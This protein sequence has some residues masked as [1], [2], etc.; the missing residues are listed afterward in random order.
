MKYLLMAL[1]TMG[2]FGAGLPASA[3]SNMGYRLLNYDQLMK[4]KKKDR[5]AY[6]V[7]LEKTLIELEEMQGPRENRS[8]SGK[9]A[10]SQLIPMHQFLRKMQPFWI[11][12]A[13]AGIRLANPKKCPNEL[14]TYNWDTEVCI[15]S[16]AFYVVKPVEASTH[17]ENLCPGGHK[18]IIFKSSS[19]P[20][21]SSYNCILDDKTKALQ[22]TAK[23]VRDLDPSK[24]HAIIEARKAA[25]TVSPAGLSCIKDQ[26]TQNE[27]DQELLNQFENSKETLCINGMFIA[28]FNLERKKCPFQDH[29]SL[30]KL[31][32]SC[33]TGQTMCW[34]LLAGLKKDGTA[35]CVNQGDV[36]TRPCNDLKKKLRDSSQWQDVLNDQENDL[37]IKTVWDE[38]TKGFTQL[39]ITNQASASYHCHECA[40]MK[41]NLLA[42]AQAH[43]NIQISCQ[44]LQPSSPNPSAQAQ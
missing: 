35:L 19:A 40:T 28:Q 12:K 31:E 17:G 30:G 34:P 26:C 23:P 9:S 22:I 36:T 21:I 18:A 44:T 15:L 2:L 16:P 39:C 38:W 13:W 20:G 11:H 6:L 29:F 32:L 27:A 4:L 7:T 42:L 24:D 8:K 1:V 43:P 41:K 5:D 10:A 33:E 14:Y 3:S 25:Q 37:A